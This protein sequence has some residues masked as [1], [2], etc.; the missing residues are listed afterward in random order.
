MA[1]AFG[2]CGIISTILFLSATGTNAR[3]A[4]KRNRDSGVPALVRIKGGTFEQRSRLTQLVRRLGST[5]F[6]SLEIGSP[7]TS[8]RVT[9]RWLYVVVRK[10]SDAGSTES[11][12]AALMVASAFRDARWKAKGPTVSGFT[13]SVSGS[14][15]IDRIERKFPRTPQAGRKPAS[16]DA[17]SRLLVSIA[18]R[19]DISIVHTRFL[20][21]F[22]RPAVVAVAS[23]AHPENY[24][25]PFAEVQDL[26]GKAKR[27][28]QGTLLVL[29]APPGGIVARVGTAPRLHLYVGWVDPALL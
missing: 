1:L 5:S 2:L 26:E 4:V 15:G 17:L 13:V 9:G 24:L 28:G 14:P 23:I 19:S 11:R 22:N 25:V 27:V 7:P 6:R 29:T 3:S 12:W 10:N 16:R 21:T 8:R 18:V 20:K